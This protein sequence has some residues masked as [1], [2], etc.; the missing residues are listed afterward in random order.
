M[1][2]FR[3]FA[4]LEAPAWASAVA[5]ALFGAMVAVWADAISKLN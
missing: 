4:R 2:R 1:N 3:S 5:L